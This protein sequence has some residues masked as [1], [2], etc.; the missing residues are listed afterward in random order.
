[1]GYLGELL[2]EHNISYD[3]VD[4]ETDPIPDSTPYHA[5][6]VFGG[7]QHANDDHKYPYFFQEKILLRRAIEQDK[8]FLGI[9]LGGQLLAHV[10]G[11]AVKRHSMTEIGFFDVPFTDE[12]QKDPLYEGLPGYQKVFQWHEDTFDL[13]AG[14]VRLATNHNTENQAFRFGRHAYGLQYH[15][16]LNPQMLDTWLHYPAFKQDIINT[17]GAEAYDTLEREQAAQY[18]V[19]RAHTRIMFENFLRISKLL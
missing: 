17:L 16:E 13:P 11:A 4:V 8:P 18:P 14:A 7:F 12:G 15:I 19:Y 3:L 5:L 2:Q 1:V 9:C 6:I 10:L